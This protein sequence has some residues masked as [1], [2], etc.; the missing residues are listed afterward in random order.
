MKPIAKNKNSRAKRLTLKV[1]RNNNPYDLAI[2]LVIILAIGYSSYEKPDETVALATVAAISIGGWWT[3][4]NFI[5]KREG[6]PR[7]KVGLTVTDFKVTDEKNVVHAVLTFENIGESLI[8]LNEFFVRFQ[9]VLPADDSKLNERFTRA[10]TEVGFDVVEKG[11]TFI[12]W[13]ELAYREVKK[14]EKDR[15]GLVH[16]EPGETQTLYADA[17]ID[18]DIQLV[19]VYGYVHNSKARSVGWDCETFH[20]V[21]STKSYGKE[22]QLRSEQEGSRSEGAGAEAGE[23]GETSPTSDCSEQEKRKRR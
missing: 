9:L 18:S 10:A 3:Y 15:E 22:G 6:A 8:K 2:L 14:E 12:E 13:P 1:W 20:T 21:R 7:A 19:R 23:G 17:I 16:V 4:T 5:R 11:R